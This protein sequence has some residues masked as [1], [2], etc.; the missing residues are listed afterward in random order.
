MLLSVNKLRVSFHTRAGVVRA[1]RDVSF[2]L[3]RGE[4][5]GIVGESGSGKS[6]TAYSIMGL[7]PQ[8]PARIEGGEAIFD[9]TDLLAISPRQLNQL[10]GRRISMIFQDPMTCLNPFLRVEEQL[11]EPLL[12]HEKINRPDARKRALAM[13][14]D[15]GIP[16]PEHRMR[17]YPHEFS[18]GMRQRVMI[19]MALITK[20]DLVI[21]DE[22]TTALDVTVQA[23]ILEL[24]K[25][26]RAELGM[27]VILISHDLGV[28]SGFCDRAMVMYAGQVMETAKTEDLFYKTRHPYTQALQKSIPA[29]HAKGTELYTIRGAPPDLIH[30]PQGCPF[31]QRCDYAVN[32]C[33][34]ED[35]NATE[36]SPAHR[37]ACLRVQKENLSL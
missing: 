22:P 10:R 17:M 12:I 23:Q 24:M 14:A 6:V 9:G 5:L 19:A 21:A 7:L 1:A 37:S 16:D 32:Y 25:K 27:A 29:L 34:L 20:P 4:T 13:L 11:M 36:V 35:V 2:Q 18:G 3:D 33:S 15:V 8:P 26:M 31:I 30:L 28:I